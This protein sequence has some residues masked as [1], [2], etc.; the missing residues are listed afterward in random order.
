VV[1]HDPGG[2]GGG[3]NIGFD[4]D[5]PTAD[6]RA[7]SN[8]S[9]GNPFFQAQLL[10]V[11]KTAPTA[12]ELE[13]IG[14]GASYSFNVEID[15]LDGQTQRHLMLPSTGGSGQLFVGHVT[16]TLCD[17]PPNLSAAALA[18]FNALRYSHVVEPI[19]N[20]DGARTMQSM[21]SAVFRA[22][23]CG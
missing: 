20:A 19:G 11:T 3:P 2:A 21:S 1:I 4:L 8:G 7:D 5:Q 16:G 18:R 6:A 22:A 9:L 17:H 23:S 12:L 13:F 15:Y 14:H 10:A